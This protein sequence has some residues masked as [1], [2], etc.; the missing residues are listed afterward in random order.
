MPLVNHSFDE[1]TRTIKTDNCRREIHTLTTGI[2]NANVASSV[3]VTGAVDTTAATTTT[4][5]QSFDTITGNGTN[6][7]LRVSYIDAAGVADATQGATISGVENFQIRNTTAG[8]TVNLNASLDAGLVKAES[9][10]SVGDVAVTNLAT[11]AKG[12]I[13]GNGTL[14][15]GASS[16]TYVD[17]ATS[18]VVDISGGTTAGAITVA[19]A[20]LT[21]AT[22]NSLGTTAN[23]VGAIDLTAGGTTRT[24]TINATSNLVTGA[25]TAAAATS[26]VITGAG[27]VN[28][29]AA[30]LA[31]T[32][33]SV[34]ASANTGGVTLALGSNVTQKV[35]GSSANDVITTGALVLTTGSVD[36]GA[37]TADVL[38]IGTNVANVATAA[39]GAKYT[40][41]EV[42][43]VNGTINM[44]NLSSGITSVQLS[45]AT[46]SVTNLTAAQAASVQAR[47]NIGATTLTLA[48][49]TGTSDVLNI[50]F[51]T[52]GT[53]AN[54]ATTAGVLTVTGFETLNLST[55]QGATAASGADR[56]TTV[57]GAIVDTS[58]TAVN[59]TGTAFTFTDAS[60]TKAVTWD[61]TALVGNGAST[62]VGLT[63][64][65]GTGMAAGS[66]VKGSAV[67]DVITITA[68]VGSTFQGNAGND[69]FVTTSTILTPTGAAS[70]V[71]I[72]GGVGTADKIQLTGAATLTDT[73]FSKVSNMEALE[74]A[75]GAVSHSVTG[76]SANTANAF[77]S[78]ITV[79]DTAAQ[80]G[81]NTYTWASG[82]YNQNVSL[83]HATT[84]T[85]ALA[86]GNQS[87]TTG[88]GTDT[89]SLTAS[90]WVGGAGSITVST[91]AGVDTITVST[92]TL[93]EAATAQ[94]VTITA[95][96]GADIINVTTHA[97]QD[98]GATGLFLNS[99]KFVVG[100]SDSTTT[101][102]DQITGFLVGTA[103]KISDVLDFAAVG[104]NTYAATA[105]TGYTAAQLTVGVSGLGAV[106]FA[107]TSAAG[108]T[109]A[110]KI[111]AVADVVIATNGDS[112]FFIDNGNTYVF[113]NNTAGD[114][115]VELVGQAGTTTLT[116]TAG[117]GAGTII[118]A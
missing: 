85:G 83:T 60:S 72:D 107:G 23:T 81:A 69:L 10:L 41:F 24:V 74:L 42:L 106:T 58:L 22:I 21:S 11:T 103:A 84:Y 92:G 4:T 94:A 99:I 5:L 50:Q 67:K 76:L 7:T 98:E 104:V 100:T 112:A 20:G 80:T 117:V 25:I 12:S 48:T 59:L 63:L 43:R 70:D 6:D 95:G 88:G 13:L 34:N 105:V 64:D 14:V 71:T 79:T 87:I 32:V 109:V 62:S 90:S 2:D 45:G 91:G 46:N 19:G 37:G 17:A 39:L 56:T 53:G 57:T 35:A 115:V 31:A 61:A 51:G 68:A 96:T 77:A 8:Q 15:N 89:I 55:N 114:S 47:A 82:L 101:A 3:L 66:I 49:A 36:A 54:A 40:N 9:Y 97:I 18:G 75:G 86:T 108:L 16:F 65:T 33:T 29:S 118:L 38:D 113:N 93:A 116:T 28:I 78:G 1:H 111:A 102:Y 30:A 26:Y 52:G 110:Q 44:A 73:S 27:T